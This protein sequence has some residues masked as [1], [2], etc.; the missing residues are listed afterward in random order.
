LTALK[1][2]PANCQ[3]EFNLGLSF[4]RLRKQDEAAE[5]YRAALR[6]NPNYAEAQIAL[7]QLQ[8]P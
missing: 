5:H 4:A 3:T 8:N 7:R 1:L 6:I 2:N